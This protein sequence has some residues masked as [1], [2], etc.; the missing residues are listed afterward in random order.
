MGCTVDIVWDSEAQVWVATSEDVPGLALES[1]SLDALLER[2][3][4]AIPELFELN[5]R[6]APRYDLTFIVEGNVVRAVNAASYAMQLLQQQMA[7]EAAAVGIDGDE[8]VDAL[9]CR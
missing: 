6:E 7:G 2:V 5:G 3:R 9:M 1:D 4:F 8:C